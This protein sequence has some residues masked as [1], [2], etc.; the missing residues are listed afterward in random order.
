MLSPEARIAYCFQTN[1]APAD[2][3]PGVDR[4]AYLLALAVFLPTDETRRAMAS[5]CAVMTDTLDL[6]GDAVLAKA[7]EFKAEMERRLK[8]TDRALTKVP[9]YV[10]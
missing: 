8:V 5:A 9:S 6:D 2:D 3:A 1:L 10:S 7:E 4:V